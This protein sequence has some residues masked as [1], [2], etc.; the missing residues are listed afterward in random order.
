M[1]SLRDM[2]SAHQQSVGGLKNDGFPTI[3]NDESRH[4]VGARSLGGGGRTGASAV[5]FL[6]H[7]CWC[8]FTELSEMCCGWLGLAV[9]SNCSVTDTEVSET[10]TS[11]HFTSIFCDVKCY[12]FCNLRGCWTKLSAELSWDHSVFQM[13]PVCSEAGTPLAVKL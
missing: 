13:C 4:C 8:F 11:L 2:F 7:S 1:Y 3:I 6:S 5:K 9:A 10:N 12:T